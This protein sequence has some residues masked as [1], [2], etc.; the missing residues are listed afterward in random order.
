[1]GVLRYSRVIVHK[2]S[3]KPN[4]IHSRDYKGDFMLCS[5]VDLKATTRI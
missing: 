2:L 3:L 5:V 1:L 4:V